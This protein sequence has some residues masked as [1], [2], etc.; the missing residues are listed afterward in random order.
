MV[1]HRVTLWFRALPYLQ[2]GY[3]YLVLA[4]EQDVLLGSVKGL[5][6]ALEDP[7]SGVVS[8][9]NASTAEASGAAHNA[10]NGGSVI[11]TA[12]S[13]PTADSGA[14]PACSCRAVLVSRSVSRTA[15]RRGRIEI[16]FL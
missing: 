5:A 12:P 6:A 8:S 3:K 14:W 1:W 10:L 13:T 16:K 15:T 7:S 2:I 9:Y 4:P 11:Y